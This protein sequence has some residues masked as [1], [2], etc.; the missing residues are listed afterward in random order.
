MVPAGQDNKAANPSHSNL[1][2][3]TSVGG[4]VCLTA[5]LSKR[6]TDVHGTAQGTAQFPIL[7]GSPT[8]G[9]VAAKGIAHGLSLMCGH[10]SV[11]CEG[12]LVVLDGLIPSRG[13]S[14][15]HY[16]LVHV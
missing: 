8:P 14:C 4:R 10:S 11:N 7:R 15:F 1:Q 2:E 3:G 16:V 9:T 13:I 5:G 12:Q 6:I